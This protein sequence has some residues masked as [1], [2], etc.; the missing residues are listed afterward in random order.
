ARRQLRHRAGQGDGGRGRAAPRRA[1]DRLA[2]R[3]RALRRARDRAAGRRGGGRA[4][5]GGAARAGVRGAAG[6]P[7]RARGREVRGRRPDRHPGARDGGEEEQRGRR[8]RREATR[9]RPRPTH[10]GGR[11]ARLDGGALMATKPRKPSTD[12]LGPTIEKLMAEAGLTYRALAEKTK[13]SAG[14]LNHI[15][16]GNRPVPSNEVL[17]RLAKALGVKP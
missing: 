17:G 1:R 10:A 4:R 3:D 5:G 8:R 13:L 14:Y 16:H 2:A 12:P 7:R 9:R 15:V 11:R 6:R